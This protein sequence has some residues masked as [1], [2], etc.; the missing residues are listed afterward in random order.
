MA[1]AGERPFSLEI[2]DVMAERGL[3]GRTLAKLVREHTGSYGYGTIA[4][5][6]SG[7][8]DP[9]LE[10]MEAICGALHLNPEKFSEYRM[11]K[12]RRQLSP[13][14]MGYAAA[15]RKLKQLES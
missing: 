8:L 3:S 13:T 5:I 14:R 11:A 6:L 15:L 10:A 7:H 1:D 9:S 2:K 4:M 12:L